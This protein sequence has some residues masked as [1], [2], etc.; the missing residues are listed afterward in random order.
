MAKSFMIAWRTGTGE[1]TVATKLQ[2]MCALVKSELET[3]TC[4]S[5]KNKARMKAEI[6]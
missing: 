5:V 4:I 3:C 1:R 6:S 2:P